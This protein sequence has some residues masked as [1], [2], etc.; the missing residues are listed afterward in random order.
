MKKV[1]VING[2]FMGRGDDVLGS[3]LLGNFLRKLWVAPEKPAAILFY[4]SGVKLLGQ[5]S[6]VLDALDG[7]ARA[8][9]DLIACGTCVGHFNLESKLAVGRVSDMQE[10]VAW[11]MSADQ[12]ITI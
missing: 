5:G 4:N 10:I 3:Q 9:V 8:G 2:E 12:V 1:V 6:L 7:L 11:K